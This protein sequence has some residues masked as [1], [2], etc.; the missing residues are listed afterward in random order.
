MSG[1]EYEKNPFWEYPFMGFSDCGEV[2]G[3]TSKVINDIQLDVIGE[4]WWGGYFVDNY[5]IRGF[6]PCRI[7]DEDAVCVEIELEFYNMIS[8]HTPPDF[9]RGYH[10]IT[11][12]I[13]AKPRKEEKKVETEPK[14]ET[15]R[16]PKEE[17]KET[18]I[19]EILEIIKTSI[20]LHA[21]L[22][23]LSHKDEKLARELWS[24]IK[25]S[26]DNYFEVRE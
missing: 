2:V 6:R 11:E 4:L 8:R 17:I 18:N 25:E 12:E 19:G 15:T 16:V 23:K 22:V 24:F 14:Q 1:L 7:Y 26:I 3:V 21:L 20:K 9:L 13:I 10:E 5:H